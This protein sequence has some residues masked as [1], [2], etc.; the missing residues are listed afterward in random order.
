MA[1]VGWHY[2]TLVIEDVRSQFDKLKVNTIL[3][4]S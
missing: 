2:R 1:V 3:S 4:L